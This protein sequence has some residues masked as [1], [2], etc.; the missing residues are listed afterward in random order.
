MG[1]SF[2]NELQN[3]SVSSWKCFGAGGVLG[4]D[5]SSVQEENEC[6]GIELNQ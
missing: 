5:E 1:D 6:K 4:D 3:W 2:R